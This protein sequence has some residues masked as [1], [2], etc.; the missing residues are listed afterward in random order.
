MQALNPLRPWEVQFQGKGKIL[1][2][3]RTQEACLKHW[4]QS[5]LSFLPGT[6]PQGQWQKPKVSYPGVALP[7]ISLATLPAGGKPLVTLNFNYLLSPLPISPLSGDRLM[8]SCDASCMR[9]VTGGSN[10]E[11][12]ETGFHV[13]LFSPCLYQRFSSLTSAPPPPPRRGITAC[14]VPS[15]LNKY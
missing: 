12:V 14:W 5:R 3:F 8:S 15:L 9:P 1:S 2:S 4:S 7:P 10:T 13:S 6:A 11:L